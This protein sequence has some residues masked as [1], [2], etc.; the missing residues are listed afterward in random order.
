M[1]DFAPNYT[2]R[3][4]VKYS[5]GGKS[6]SQTW[7]VASSVTDP[8]GL[9]SKV[10]LYYADIEGILY[11]DFTIT[12]ADWAL[13]DSDVF[14]PV[15]PPAS[16]SGAIGIAGFKPTD[17]AAYIGFVGRST[18]GGK[19]RIF[20]YGTN[21][22]SNIRT[23]AFDDWRVTSAEAAVISDAVVRLNETAPALVANDDAVVVWYEYANVKYNDRW[24]RRMRR[25]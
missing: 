1:A 15:T 12:G 20:Q 7:R 10:E 3:L 11:D 24:V 23:G 2:A 21:Y 4:R 5:Q 22:G 19:A 13:A 6:H 16:P 14:L 8:A 9:V 25:G 18:L 17:A